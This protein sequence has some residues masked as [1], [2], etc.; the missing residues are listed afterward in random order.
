MSA[1]ADI[2]E[3]IRR[4]RAKYDLKHEQCVELFLDIT[5]ALE[6]D[7][8]DVDLDDENWQQ[9]EKTKAEEYLFGEDLS[10]SVEPEIFK[11]TR[12]A[13]ENLGT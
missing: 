11:G 7:V 4:S 6:W 3:T 10:P 5:G 2:T 8:F 13:L 1:L 9:I 12:E